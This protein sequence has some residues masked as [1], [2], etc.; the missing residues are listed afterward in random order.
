MDCCSI[1]RE[2]GCMVQRPC[3]ANTT[4]PTNAYNAPTV[5]QTTSNG[6]AASNRRRHATSAIT[7]SCSMLNLIITSIDE[8]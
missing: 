2:I 5:T 1:I 6:V 3:T 8:K 7:A 4:R